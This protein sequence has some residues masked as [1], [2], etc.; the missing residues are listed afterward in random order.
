MAPTSK[1]YKSKQGLVLA[2]R[3]PTPGVESVPGPASHAIFAIDCSIES[4]VDM[5]DM[6]RMGGGWRSPGALPAKRYSNVTFEIPLVG[7]WRMPGYESQVEPDWGELMY[8]SG[9]TSEFDYASTYTAGIRSAQGPFNFA[10]GAPAIIVSIDDAAVDTF[11]LDITNATKYPNRSRVTAAQIVADIT[12]A[13]TAQGATI[14][15]RKGLLLIKSNETANTARIQVVRADNGTI[16]GNSTGTIDTAATGTW[17]ATITPTVG[18]PITA[19]YATV[20]GSPTAD[21]I[22]AGLRASLTTALLVGGWDKLIAVTGATD[23]IILTLARASNLG[24]T[25]AI[26]P[27]GAG[28]ASIVNTFTG[29]AGTSMLFDPSEVLGALLVTNVDYVPYSFICNDTVTVYKYYFP[30]CAVTDD[31]AQLFRSFGCAFNPTFMFDASGECTIKFDGKGSFVKP[32]DTTFPT[33]YQF[34]TRGDGMIGLGAVFSMEANDGSEGRSDPYTKLEFNP[35]WTVS[36]RVDASGN[37]NSSGIASYF[38]TREG[39]MTGSYDPEVVPVTDF[40]R[41]AKVLNANRNSLEVLYTSPAGS[42]CTVTA[43]NL[44]Y[45]SPKTEGN[46]RLSY[47]QPFYLRDDSDEG[48]DYFRISLAS[49]DPGV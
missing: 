31:E 15:A 23:E 10:T 47:S 26:T 39:S 1:F 17:T 38:L 45:G 41:W 12:S 11:T 49:I 43:D 24:F 16:A 21:D 48:D 33:G 6:K 44:Q 35:N 29:S 4:V 18:D 37:I 7:V 25:F 34:R 32:V 46:D 13:V 14:I 30:Q 19:S 22:A 42:T 40:D 5:V 3:E 9:F 8:G 2:R 27:A 20:G 36:E 28:A